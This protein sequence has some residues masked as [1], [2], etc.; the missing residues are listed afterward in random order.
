MAGVGAPDRQ[1]L[2]AVP[3]RLAHGGEL[4]AL[5]HHVAA[6][7]EYAGAVPGGPDQPE[8]AP[9][10]GWAAEPGTAYHALVFA[11]RVLPVLG[12]YDVLDRTLADHLHTVQL[13]G[14]DRPRRVRVAVAAVAGLAPVDGGHTRLVFVSGAE[15]LVRESLQAVGEAINRPRVIAPPSGGRIIVR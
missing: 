10:D 1:Q 13:H 15:L 5:L 11:A 8:T 9:E 4:V 2:V 12:S 7:V 6:L 3:F 14:V